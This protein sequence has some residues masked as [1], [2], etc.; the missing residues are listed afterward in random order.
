MRCE[1]TKRRS[2]EATKGFT[3]VEMVI[4]IGVIVV[5]AA[6][7]LSVSVAV[8]EGSEIRQTENTIRLLTTAIQEWEA[9]ADRR[10][11]Y[12]QDD[13]PYGGEVYEIK[14]NMVDEQEATD[15]L[16]TIIT[17]PESV[18]KI[19]AQINP[20]A[21]EDH[22]EFVNPDTNEQVY[23]MRVKDAWDHQIIAVF[24][25]RTWMNDAD[26]GNLYTY[27][28]DA[29]GTI[30]TEQ[31]EHRAIAVNRQIC[32]VSPG[33]DGEFGDFMGDEDA[34]D[35]TDDNIFSYEPANKSISQP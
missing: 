17:K 32:F 12:G 16:M 2:D 1:A 26:D 21:V 27:Q 24:P 22:V 31:E 33:P 6:L 5:L 9:V 15:W 8:V 14:A 35:E 13:Q 3:L 10:I 30:R 11:S 34:V 29:D 4:V 28:R 7:T 18:R 20:D 23:T 19:L 25:G